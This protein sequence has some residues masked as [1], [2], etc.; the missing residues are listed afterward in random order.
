MSAGAAYVYRVDG[1]E[2]VEEQKLTASDGAESDFFGRSVWTD[3]S[4]I[5]SGAYFDD[6]VNGTSGSAYVYRFDGAQWFEQQK[7]TAMVSSVGGR[8]GRSVAVQGDVILIGADGDR[9]LGVGAGA[10][11]VFDFDGVDWTE[12]Q[13][14]TAPDGLPGD[15]FGGAVA[16]DGSVLV[17][18]EDGDDDDV[19][20]VDTGSAWV[21]RFNGVSW[22]PEQKL[23]ASDAAPNDSFGRVVAIDDDVIVVGAFLHAGAALNSGAAYVF[24]YDGEDWIEEAILTASDA[25]EDDLFGNA[26]AVDGNW[27]IVGANHE[28]QDILDSDLGSA[29]VYHYNGDEWVE[30]TILKAPNGDVGGEFGRSVSIDKREIAVGAPLSGTEPANSGSAYAFEVRN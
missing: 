20:G 7:L 2:I 5:V 30:T 1:P 29:Y 21:Y 18:G 22:A 13:K 11:Y 23:M 12:S 19:V 8:F 25:E 4:T 15:G 6:D 24:R 10:A 3:G 28:D 16:L 9:E 17:V 14:L 26:V 27:I